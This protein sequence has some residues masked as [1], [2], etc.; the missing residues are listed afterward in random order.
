HAL[1]AG[2]DELARG[3]LPGVERLSLLLERELLVAHKVG[4]QPAVLRRMLDL[5]VV[6]PPAPHQSTRTR[7]TGTGAG[8]GAT[9]TRGVVSSTIALM[10]IIGSQNNI[11]MTR[12]PL[13]HVSRFCEPCVCN[14]GQAI[15]PSPLHLNNVLLAASVPGIA[16]TNGYSKSHVVDG[17]RTNKAARGLVTDA[18]AVVLARVVIAITG[19]SSHIPDE[20][21]R[22]KRD[23]AQI[24]DPAQDFAQRQ[25]CAASPRL[26]CWTPDLATAL[27]A[28]RSG[29]RESEVGVARSGFAKP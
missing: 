26:S 16:Y 22:A 23:G 10:K 21:R 12:T 19:G 27:R 20:H 24:R 1:V 2:G 11:G 14:P 3:L 25:Y 15:E 17:T 18:C 7:F 13:A 5:L 9:G 4:P 29:V 8:L 6:R 28:A